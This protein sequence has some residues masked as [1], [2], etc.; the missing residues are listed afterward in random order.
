MK[1]R[2]W[3]LCSCLFFIACKK[4]HPKNNPIVTGG[5]YGVSIR[6]DKSTYQPGEAVTFT[7]D[8]ILP[9]SVKLR[10]RHLNETISETKLTGDSWKWTPP[11][12]DYTGYLVDIYE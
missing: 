9:G 2:F 6:T 1:T 5:S 4:N 3:I 7:I 10:Y 11:S 12:T 8:K